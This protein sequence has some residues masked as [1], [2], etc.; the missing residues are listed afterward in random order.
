MPIS[1]KAVAVAAPALL[2]GLTIA[3]SLTSFEITGTAREA[4]VNEPEVYKS[5]SGPHAKGPS[6]VR[7]RASGLGSGGRI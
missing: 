5:V 1:R 7:E 2:A 4:G 6:S 3:G